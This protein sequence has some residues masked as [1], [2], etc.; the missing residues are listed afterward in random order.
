MGGV[1]RRVW[2]SA[3]SPSSEGEIRLNQGLTQCILG[4]FEG[5]EWDTGILP[6]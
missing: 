4:K 6:C 2:K 3:R 5:V 1:T